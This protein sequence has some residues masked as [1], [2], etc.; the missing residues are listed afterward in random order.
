MHVTP[1]HLSGLFIRS[2]VHDFLRGIRI[3]GGFCTG[4]VLICY[5]ADLL[6]YYTGGQFEKV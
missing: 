2:V 3:K 1:P 4:R 6:K 5:Y